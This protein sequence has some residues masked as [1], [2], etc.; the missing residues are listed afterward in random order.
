MVDVPFVAKFQEPRRFHTRALVTRQQ[1]QVRGRQKRRPA[2]FPCWPQ[3]LSWQ[4]VRPFLSSPSSR[5]LLLDE[6]ADMH[7]S[8]AYFEMRLLMAR[9]LWR[10]D[11]ELDPRSADWN[12]QEAYLLWEKP[13]MFVKLVPRHV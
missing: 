3:K 7:R 1:H 12:R 13:P 2:T 6:F 10:F 8:L 4:E 5:F 9:L 11:L